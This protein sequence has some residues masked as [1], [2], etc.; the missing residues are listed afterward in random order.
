MRRARD[1]SPSGSIKRVGFSEGKK[2]GDDCRDND[3]GEPGDSE[4][5]ANIDASPSRK[6]L[7]G[8]ARL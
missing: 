4:G 6:R 8:L 7:L 2:V 1:G 3:D 5:E